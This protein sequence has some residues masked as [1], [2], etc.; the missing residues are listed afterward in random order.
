MKLP[1]AALAIAAE[2]VP[3]SFELPAD[4]V[5][6][7]VFVFAAKV[8]KADTAVSFFYTKYWKEIR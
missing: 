2:T 8:L 6:Q 4:G 7:P 5:T 1:A 3:K